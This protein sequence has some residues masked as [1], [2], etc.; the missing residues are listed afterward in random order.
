MTKV[1]LD[2]PDVEPADNRHS[3]CAFRFSCLKDIYRPRAL[4]KLNLLSSYC[5]DASP[6]LQ[7]PDQAEKDEHRRDIDCHRDGQSKRKPNGQSEIM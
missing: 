1:L 2:T 5:L 7:T 6:R 4:A 3:E